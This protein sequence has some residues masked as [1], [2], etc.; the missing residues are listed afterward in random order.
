MGCGGEGSLFLCAWLLPIASSHRF[1]LLDPLQALL[2][3][4]GQLESLGKG[5]NNKEGVPNKAL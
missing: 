1:R 5:R 3:D 4:F 2:G